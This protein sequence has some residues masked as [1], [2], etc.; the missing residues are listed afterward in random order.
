MYIVTNNLYI[1][2]QSDSILVSDFVSKNQSTHI[3][4]SC[5]VAILRHDVIF[6]L[7]HQ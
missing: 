5:T 3:D 2:T 7:S 1:Y 4:F 6:S